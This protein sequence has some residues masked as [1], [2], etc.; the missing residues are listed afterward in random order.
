MSPRRSRAHAGTPCGW[1][2]PG[3]GD[4]VSAWWWRRWRRGRSPPR[5]RVCAIA[6]RRWRPARR[7]GHRRSGRD[8]LADRAGWG[9]DPAAGAG[10][11][12][13]RTKQS[14]RHCRAGG[15]H[16]WSRAC[17]DDRPGSA[18][19]VVGAVRD[20]ARLRLRLVPRSRARPGPTPRPPGG[21]CL[22][23]EDTLAGLTA[24]YYALTYLGFAAPYLLALDAHLAS[25][26]V[27]LSISAALAL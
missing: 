7:R 13:A 23:G 9:A 18:G 24:A 8:H 15:A 4:R 19:L 10:V 1:R 11:G 5:D 2:C 3:C 17:A 26:P 25:Y 20:R 6:E 21:P 27:L 16:W 12:G 22:A 14:C